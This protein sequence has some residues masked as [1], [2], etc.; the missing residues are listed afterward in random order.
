MVIS[1]EDVDA[2]FVVVT[3]FAVSSLVTSYVSSAL[4]V[5]VSSPI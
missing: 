3:V 1:V 2:S 5:A 4:V